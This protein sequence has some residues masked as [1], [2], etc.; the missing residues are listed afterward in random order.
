MLSMLLS[1]TACLISLHVQA[2][3]GSAHSACVVKENG[4][5]CTTYDGIKK[6]CTALIHLDR[7]A[8]EHG[9]V[10]C[11]DRGQVVVS[12]PCNGIKPHTDPQ[13]GHVFTGQCIRKT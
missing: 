5:V 12:L 6:R 4:Y 3:D 11:Y 9:V 7:C 10:I 2:P 13:T 8:N 1:T